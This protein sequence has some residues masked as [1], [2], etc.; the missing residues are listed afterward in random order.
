[1]LDLRKQIPSPDGASRFRIYAGIRINYPPHLGTYF[2]LASAFLIAGEAHRHFNLECDVSIQALDHAPIE[3]IG[4]SLYGLRKPLYFVKSR[5]ERLSFIERFYSQFLRHSA[6]LTG[7]NFELALYTDAQKNRRFRKQFFQSLSLRSELKWCISPLHALSGSSQLIGV[8][9]PCKTCGFSTMFGESIELISASTERLVVRS[10]CR[11]HGSFECEVSESPD[12]ILDFQKVLRNI[13]KESVLAEEVDV[14]HIVTKGRDWIQGCSF[15]DRGL[16]I[17]NVSRRPFR[18]FSP[19]LTTES[20]KKLSKSEIHRD[21]AE[22]QELP[23][24]V[25]HSGN[26]FQDQ[27]AVERLFRAVET[28]LKS[29]LSSHD[30]LSFHRF[31]AITGLRF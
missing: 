5:E 24:W 8:R 21:P 3:V 30:T 22:F 6:G 15:V 31:Q 12:E 16:Q 4:N 9:F 28:I 17:L 10:D 18:F 27:E 19:V 11:E 29:D 7:T 20:G 26:Y 13:I 1:M 14:F 25:K 23:D 2:I